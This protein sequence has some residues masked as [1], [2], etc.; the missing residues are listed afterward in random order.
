MINENTKV[1]C[2]CNTSEPL[3]V[4]TLLRYKKY[5]DYDDDDDDEPDC[6]IPIVKM[7]DGRELIVFGIVIP[8]SIEMY[9]FL[10]KL[11]PKRQWEI[12]AEIKLA[13]YFV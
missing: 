9:E 11:T 2:R 7:E 13:L 4:G 1:I 6:C 3:L 8:Y 5:W 10:T 12:L